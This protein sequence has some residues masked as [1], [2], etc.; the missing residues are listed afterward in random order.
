MN[1]DNKIFLAALAF[2]VIIIAATIGLISLAAM[3]NKHYG[4]TA[5]VLTI[6]LPLVVV[7][8]YMSYVLFQHTKNKG[9]DEECKK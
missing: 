2:I 8:V 7:T 1:E 3:I 4:M 6:I 5:G 9:E